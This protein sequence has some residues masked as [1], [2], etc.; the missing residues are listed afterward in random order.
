[1]FRL[2]EEEKGNLQEEEE[3]EGDS[4]EGEHGRATVKQGVEPED[5]VESKEPVQRR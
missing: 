2:E 4:E 3:Q 1:M 5:S